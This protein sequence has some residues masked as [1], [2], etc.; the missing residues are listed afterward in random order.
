MASRALIVLL[1]V[2]SCN[3]PSSAHHSASAIF[4]LSKTATFEGKLTSVRW[5]NPHIRILVDVAG[6]QREA[7]AW[8][9]ESQPP[10]W[11]RRVGVPVSTFENAIGQS[12]T[13]VAYTA[14]NGEPFGFLTEIKFEDGT[15]FV[16]VDDPIKGQE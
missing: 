5:I 10:Q 15:S 4:D 8:V 3:T 16:M 13:I 1:G 12:V 9:F 2:L 7:E 14:R 6:E 11:F